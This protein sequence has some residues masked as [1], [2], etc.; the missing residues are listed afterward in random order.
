MTTPGTATGLDHVGRFLQA[1]E[2]FTD[3]LAAVDLEAPVPGC[4]GWSAYD[5]VRHLGNV[6]AWAATIAETGRSAPHQDDAPRSHRARAVRDW[7]AGK[8]EDLYR[9]LRATDPS[10]SCWNFVD[11]EGVAGFWGRRQ[12][13]ET[14][15]HTLDLDPLAGSTTRVV[16]DV[17]A[18]GV[19]EVLTVFLRRMHA[20]GFPVPLVAPLC[21]VCEDTGHAWTLA[22]RVGRFGRPTS[23]S[24]Q[25]LPAQALPT[26][27][28]GPAAETTPAGVGG[29]PLVV[30]GLDPSA[31][32]VAAPAVLLYRALWKRAPLEALARS[33]DPARIDAFLTARL[34][35]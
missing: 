5:L 8:A 27:S 20:R 32:Q 23:S 22:P 17:A 12:L 26:Q 24:A 10:R 4:P 11:G 34:V 28:R 15:V 19:D 30:E 7:Y 35:P 33:G 6:H 2:R 9:V 29:P 3:R 31:D 18:D 14:T 1:A 13:H 25:S 21:L 16:P